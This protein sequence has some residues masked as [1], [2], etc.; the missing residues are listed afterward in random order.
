MPE[1]FMF[2]LSAIVKAVCAVV[3]ALFEGILPSKISS[4]IRLASIHREKGVRNL[5]N[6]FDRS[7]IIL[8]NYGRNF[9]I[10]RNE[11]NINVFMV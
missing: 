2:C 11:D 1:T 5:C 8:V 3:V 4:D 10:P 7:C 9:R 6:L